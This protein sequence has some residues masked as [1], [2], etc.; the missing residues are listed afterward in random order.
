MHVIFLGLGTTFMPART[1][2]VDGRMVLA[3]DARASCM[4]PCA[5]PGRGCLRTIPQA[6][7]PEPRQ[8]RALCFDV[9]HEHVANSETS[10]VFQPETKARFRV[11][12]LGLRVKITRI[13]LTLRDPPRPGPAHPREHGDSAAPKSLDPKQ[14]GL[15]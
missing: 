7:N 12:V 8:N 9:C 14:S 11:Y 13:I 4:T 6:R 2:L 3:M 15:V 1:S 5:H 10:A